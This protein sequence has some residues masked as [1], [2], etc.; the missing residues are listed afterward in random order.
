MAELI[1]NELEIASPSAVRGAARDF[2]AALADTPQFKAIEEAA[3]RLRADEAAQHTMQAY[4]AKQQSLQ[5]LLMLNAVSA[6]ERAELERLRQ[7]FLT[8]PSVRAYFQA[9]DDLRAL[10]QT[11]AVLL[12]QHIGIDFASACG[13]GCC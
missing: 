12:S 6:E 4:Q 10:C 7:A 11:T 8:Q 5:A 3:E 13:S 9:E 1:L 2:A